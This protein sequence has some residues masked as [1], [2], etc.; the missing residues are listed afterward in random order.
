MESRILSRNAWVTAVALVGFLAACGEP[1]GVPTS[2]MADVDQYVASLPT[3]ST[4][5]PT[6]AS[7]N[8]AIG[9]ESAPD[10][11]SI[12]PT[13]YQCTTTPYSL[14]D[15]PDKVTIFNPD[16]EIM[17]L[18]ALLQGSGYKDGLGS[19]AE[20]PIR[21][22][23]PL[24]VFID[25]LSENV[26]ATVEN[27]NPANLASAIGDL[28]EQAE[29]A[30]HKAGSKTFFEQKETHSLEQSAL[31]LGVSVRYL[32][33]TV[34]SE[35]SF[36]Q[37]REENTLTAYFIQQMFTSSVVLPQTPSAMFSDDFTAE[38]LNQQ[39]AL[40]RIGPDNL[41][42]FISNIV[43][44]RM[45]MLTM[46]STHTFDQM[47][48]ALSASNDAIGS[49]SINADF[50]K[51]LN[52][53][54][55]RVSTVGGNDQGVANLIKT[56]QLGDYFDAD[57]SLQQARPLSY[58]VRNLADNSIATVSETTE[59]NLKQCATGPATPTGATY[60]LTLDKINLIADGCDGVFAPA[61]EL[62]YSFSLHTDAGTRLIISRGSNMTVQLGE[63][64][65]HT[66]PGNSNSVNLYADGR[67]SMRVTG[68][69]WDEDSNSAD[70]R[71]GSWDLS[72]GYG[73]ANG[74]RFFTRSENG[75][76]T[77]LYLTIT[78]SVDLFD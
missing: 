14:T 39:V 51:V 69:A 63:G 56:G 50:T 58:T 61:V 65:S 12:G 57:L 52:E 75:C 5:A 33:T 25:L 4:F 2:E 45:L 44:G 53:S 37:Q 31:E 66:L 24:T 17:W 43:W 7:A 54:E 77:R 10:V 74:Q 35:L 72:W 34:N 78:K 30:G 32:G 11:F 46:T 40:G 64:G 28:I 21:Q 18:G 8:L 20:L 27:P 42:T 71:I 19:L 41:P 55:I 13:E 15:T 9:P 59:Y 68:N 3:W 73:T 62:Y 49:G 26:Q 70:E 16:S 29:L 22:R 67:G 76:T 60:K 36:Q 47:R 1:I 6:L 38:Q 23:A 48:A